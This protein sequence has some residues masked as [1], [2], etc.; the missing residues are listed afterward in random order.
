MIFQSQIIT[1]KAGSVADHGMAMG[2]QVLT[3]DGA[4]PVEFLTPGDRIVTRMGSRKLTSIEVTI[5]QSARVIRLAADT[6][7]VDRPMEEICVSPDQPILVRDWRAKAMAGTA[8]AMIAAARLVDGEYIRMETVA[9]M[10]FY[11]LRFAED[12]VIYAGGLELSC[13]PAK[14]AA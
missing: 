6:L 2:T 11:T 4:L 9:E 14:V 12:V 3:M 13:T 8:T 1:T 5:V 7:G 10:R